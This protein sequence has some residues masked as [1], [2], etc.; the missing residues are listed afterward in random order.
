MQIGIGL[1]NPV[2]GAPG[3]LLI[4]WAKRAEERGFA[5]LTTIDRIAYPSFDSLAALSAAAGA[6]S[7]IGLVTNILLA[8][9]YPPA[10]LAKSAASIDQ[11]S[12][13]RLTLGLAPGGREDD[14]VAAGSEFHTRGRAFDAELDLLHR[15]WRG[16]H[17]AGVTEAVCPR[18][19]KDD[20]I[21]IMIG[22]QS[23]KAAQ[24]TAQWGVGWT[25]AGGGAEMAAPFVERIRDAWRQAGRGGEPRLAALVYFSLGAD[26]EPDSHAYLRDYYAF[27]GPYTEQI[28]AAALRSEAAV[29][30]TARAFADAGFTEL[31]LDPTVAS[32]DQV[33]RLADVAL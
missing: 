24:R 14:Y 2:R 11:L 17:V 31:Y 27:L 16:E 33:D 18:P 8:P 21:P 32:L 12:G 5:A 22:G 10:L 23:D 30:D 26:A 4:D 15:A 29:R 3:P 1:P 19:V 25:A 13:G 9:A 20:R 28:D 7:R 6:T